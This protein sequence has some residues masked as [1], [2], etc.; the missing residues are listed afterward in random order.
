M[1]TCCPQSRESKTRLLF[2]SVYAP[3]I[4]T[5]VTQPSFI[6]ITQHHSPNII[7]PTKT[8]Q[9]APPSASDATSLESAYD[10]EPFV[11]NTICIRGGHSPEK[12]VVSMPP[13]SSKDV[14]PV[15]SNTIGI[16][17]GHSLEKPGKN[18]SPQSANDV[19]PL[20][21]NKFSIQ[22]IHSVDQGAEVEESHTKFRRP[23]GCRQE[24]RCR[25]PETQTTSSGLPKFVPRLRVVETKCS[26]LRCWLDRFIFYVRHPI[27]SLWRI[28]TWPPVHVG[29]ISVFLVAYAFTGFYFQVLERE[30]PD[31][32]GASP[33]GAFRRAWG[34]STS[35]NALIFVYLEIIAFAYSF[36]EGGEFASGASAATRLA[37][38]PIAVEP[39]LQGLWA[40][41]AAAKDECLVS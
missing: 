19:E 39:F 27:Y 30:M 20:A 22:E 34:R 38:F 9:P 41:A 29:W 18:T 17:D 21:N 12:P 2:P 1:R 10:V 37:L 6:N 13:E 28:M 4:S 36:Y 8:V 23:P 35:I 3:S 25:D 14:K 11:N 40:M 24:F 15:V 31:P 32:C 5:G 33:G 16:H 26:H 7:S